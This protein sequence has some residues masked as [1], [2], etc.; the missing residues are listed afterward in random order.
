MG[1][2]RAG[3]FIGTAAGKGTLPS[4]TVWE[5]AVGAGVGL[6]DALLKGG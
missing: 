6:G 3:R 5:A 4:E 2:E 1:R